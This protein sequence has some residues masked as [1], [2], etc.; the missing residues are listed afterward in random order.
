MFTFYG[1]GHFPRP[2]SPKFHCW[3]KKTFWV[4]PAPSPSEKKTKYFYEG[5]IKQESYSF[6]FIIFS[7]LKVKGLYLRSIRTF[8]NNYDIG[9]K[10]REE[11]PG[12]N[13]RHEPKRI[14]Y[15]IVETTSNSC[16]IQCKPLNVI[17]LGQRQS[18]N[19]NQMITLTEW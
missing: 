4:N 5:I 7:L 9:K 16:Q 11:S 15:N 10:K 1:R 19:I 2:R 13:N 14:K 18:D 6:S 8:L 17:F 12:N 3:V